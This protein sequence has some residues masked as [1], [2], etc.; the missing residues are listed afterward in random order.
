MS[1]IATTTSVETAQRHQE[2][3]KLRLRGPAPPEAVSAPGR[4]R[5]DGPLS[6][7]GTLDKYPSFEVTPSIGREFSKELQLTDLLNAPNADELIRDLAV[8]SE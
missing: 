3:L 6:Y 7:N 5:L 4:N 1:P 8:L 2:Q